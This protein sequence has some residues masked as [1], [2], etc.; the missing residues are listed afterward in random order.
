MRVST[1]LSP[2]GRLRLTKPF[3][4]FSSRFATQMFEAL[5]PRIASTVL[6]AI[7][8]AFVRPPSRFFRIPTYG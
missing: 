4:R 8:V 1:S 5:N 6:G 2:N 7:A 3:I